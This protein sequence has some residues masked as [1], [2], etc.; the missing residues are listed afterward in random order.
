MDK[1]YIEVNGKREYIFNMS[2]LIDVIR[3]NMGYDT[4]NLIEKEAEDSDMLKYYEKMKFDSD[5]ESF[6]ASLED[7]ARAF[8][9]I[10]ELI[11]DFEDKIEN[12]KMIAVKDVNK[13]LEQINKTINEQI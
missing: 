13:L 11:S 12:R 6:E 7:N 3:D 8:Q 4:A 2:K 9:D 5:M 10:S 1:Q